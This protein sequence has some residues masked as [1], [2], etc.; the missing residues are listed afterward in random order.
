MLKDVKETALWKRNKGEF[1]VIEDPAMPLKTFDLMGG[2]LVI[3]SVG[4]V[5]YLRN[6]RKKNG[7]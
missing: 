5:H 7:I 4:L 2:F 1:S 6:G 3:G